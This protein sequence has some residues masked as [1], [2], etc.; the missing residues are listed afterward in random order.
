MPFCIDF[1]SIFP[2]D[3]APQTHQNEG[4]SML[5]CLPMLT[6]IADPF[7]L[8]VSSQ[9]GPLD[10]PAELAGWIRKVYFVFLKDPMLDA[11]L[12][13]TWHHFPLKIHHMFIKLDLN[14][15]I[16][17]WSMLAQSWGA[18][19]RHAGYFYVKV[20]RRDFPLPSF[21]LRWLSVSIFSCWT[22]VVPHREVPRTRWRTP[23]GL[24][25]WTIF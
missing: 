22:P 1:G 15:L 13:P 17:F 10:P 21:L 3:S 24:G 9:F 11:I 14:C 2:P 23:P 6:S 5:R 16:D 18:S 8:D 25:F 12:I 7:L 20:Q 4:R 19:W